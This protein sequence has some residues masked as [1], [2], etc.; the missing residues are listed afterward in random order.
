MAE[1]HRLDYTES[2]ILKLRDTLQDYLAVAQQHV[3][4]RTKP[5]RVDRLQALAIPRAAQSWFEECETTQSWENLVRSATE[6]IGHPRGT[7]G[8]AGALQHWFRRRGIYLSILRNE[9]LSPGI[10]AKETIH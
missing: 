8:T 3:R 5:R 1:N 9:E 7:L 6:V 4:D 2:E 10:V